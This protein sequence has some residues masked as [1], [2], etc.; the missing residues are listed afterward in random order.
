MTSNPDSVESGKKQKEE[1]N[2]SKPEESEEDGLKNPP[3]EAPQEP[4]EKKVA[5]DVESSQN[6]TT[7]STEKSSHNLLDQVKNLIGNSKAESQMKLDPEGKQLQI[8]D[9]IIIPNN[10]ATTPTEGE[11]AL[12]NLAKIA[13]RYQNS[14]DSSD[15]S[16]PK[17]PKLDDSLSKATPQ[18]PQAATPTTQSLAAL[19]AMNPLSMTPAQQQSLFALLQP[20]L[21]MPPSTKA[22]PP[23]S[24]A[25][26]SGSGG[27]KNLM[28][29]SSLFN[30]FALGDP[31]KLGPEAM[32]LLQMF[33]S[34]LKAAVGG[35]SSTSVTPTKSMSSSPKPRNASGSS[36]AS[37]PSLQSAKDRD[38][39]KITRLPADAKRPPDLPGL[40]PCAFAQT[41]NIYTNP[42]ADLAKAKETN[43]SG[44]GNSGGDALDLSRSRR[45]HPATPTPPM[46]GG[47]DG[48]ILKKESALL[49]SV[50]MSE[51]SNVRKNEVKV[52]PFSAEALL[53]KST[54]SAHARSFA[55]TP[56]RDRATPPRAS[57]SSALGN[58]A[59]ASPLFSPQTAGSSSSDKSK[60]SPWHTPVTSTGR[61]VMSTAAKPAIPVSPVV[62]EDKS[63][64]DLSF[65]AALLGLGS[66]T[67]STSSAMAAAA[68]AAAAA[69]GGA[70]PSVSLP[71]PPTSFGSLSA[72]SNPYLAFAAAGG[73]LPKT[74][75]TSAASAQ[76]SQ[77][78]FPSPFMDPM[79]AYYT[80]LYSQSLYGMSP[81]AG[82]RLP[83]MPP[84][85]ASAPHHG[86]PSSMDLMALHAMMNRGSN[87]AAA[88]AANSNPYAAAA[89]AAAA[90][91]AGYPPGLS[92]LLGYPGFPP[93]PSSGRKDP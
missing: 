63:K 9:L 36:T 34:S 64:T 83:G 79:A 6:L 54:G 4:P 5:L 55:S 21:F 91:S 62:R 30:P 43:S 86:T 78:S 11:S 10:V 14:K 75:T 13:S 89:A 2:T 27:A 20:G 3:Q 15:V 73:G 80:A 12:Q 31:S 77:G 84:Q 41:S 23:T 28:S 71:L 50:P 61:P 59:R 56:K 37:S 26:G 45:G 7:T 47:T 39:S 69:A 70:N 1:L 22:T 51:H 46:G 90:A 65:Q 42:F 24:A 16:V 67:A 52:S 92:G 82:M 40:S 17:K 19:A 68:A 81:Y 72:A 60:A 53:S 29:S 44:S 76:A 25:S 18:P 33:D 87:P 48:L 38:R 66:T 49:K 32:K 8:D 93:A 57:P 74:T 58:Y 88:A 35:A 85:G